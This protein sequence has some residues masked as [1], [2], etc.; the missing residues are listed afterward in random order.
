ML[1]AE[2]AQRV[3]KVNPGPADALLLQTVSIHISLL[4]KK[5]TALDLHSLSLSI[6]ICINNM[7]QVT[8]LAEN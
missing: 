2:Y 6:W 3:V 8:W 7:D 1:P 4:L 5:P